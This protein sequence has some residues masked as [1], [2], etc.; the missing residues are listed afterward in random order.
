MKM[1]ESD[2]IGSFFFLDNSVLIKIESK[3]FLHLILFREDIRLRMHIDRI[4]AKSRW[5]YQ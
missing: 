5:N 1:I 3:V 4:L 2:S